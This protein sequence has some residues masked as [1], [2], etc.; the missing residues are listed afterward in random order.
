VEASQLDSPSRARAFSRDNQQ[1]DWF[2]IIVALERKE[3]NHR[4]IAET[5]GNSVGSIGF[6]KTGNSAPNHPSGEAMIALWMSV[7][8][9]PRDQVPMKKDGQLSAAMVK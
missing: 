8:G 6:W 2:L 7:T 3:F 5:I 9:M 4:R 1:V